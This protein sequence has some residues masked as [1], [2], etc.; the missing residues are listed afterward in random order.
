MTYQGGLLSKTL[1]I[2]IILLFI[3]VA[4]QPSIAT[5]EPKSIDVEYFDVTTEFIGLEKEYTTKL[6]KEEIQELD[7]LYDSISDRLNKSLSI[8]VTIGIFKDAILELD[9]F[10]L[11][12]DVGIKETEK[13]VLDCYQRTILMKVFERAYNREK[14]SVFLNENIFCL[15]FGITSGLFFYSYLAYL[16]AFLLMLFFL[17]W[18]PISYFIMMFMFYFFT[19]RNPFCLRRVIVF[20]KDLAKGKIISFGLNGVRYWNGMLKGLLGDYEGEGIGVLG[21][22]GLK[23]E[24]VTKP[25]Q[26]FF[27]FARRV[28]IEGS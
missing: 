12:G 15:I 14:T 5:V 27:G 23:I 26:Y 25:Y 10:G 24:V 9:R 6:T 22:K 28:R 11:L 8:E 20:P 19:I 21:F 7:T 3:G 13:L 2:G 18:F 1:V 17:W 16:S 4:I